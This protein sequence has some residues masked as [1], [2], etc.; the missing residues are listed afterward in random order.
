[1]VPGGIREHF[2][3]AFGFR[4]RCREREERPGIEGKTV[5]AR[6]REC[7]FEDPEPGHRG[8]EIH[9]APRRL[10]EHLAV[11]PI[12]I[13]AG[14]PDVTRDFG[15]RHHGAECRGHQRNARSAVRTVNRGSLAAA[16]IKP[17]APEVIHIGVFRELMKFSVRIPDE[18]KRFRPD[19]VSRPG[20]SE[21]IA[22]G[23]PE[24]RRM[25]EMLDLRGRVK[26]FLRREFIH[27]NRFLFSHSLAPS[28][29]GP[30][31]G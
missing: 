6:P 29:I 25:E 2:L 5:D 27:H 24:K 15:S 30:R 31:P 4:S 3:R 28:P 13:A 17:H 26:R 14:R 1:M 20:L 23:L 9:E 10:H 22:R 16:S 18:F 19:L 21:R 8:G 11:I 12:D 7:L